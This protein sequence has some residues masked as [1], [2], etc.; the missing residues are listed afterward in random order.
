[1]VGIVSD[2]DVRGAA[3]DTTSVDAIM[4]PNPVTTTAATP[5]EDAAA[6]MRSRKIGA[7]P[8]LDGAELVGIVSESDLLMALIEL[9]R[10]TDPT[11][12]IDLD[13]EDD[14]EAAH[15]VRS[16]LERHGG[17][18]SWLTAIRTHGG[19]QRISLRV[20]LPHAH[21]PSQMLEEAGFSVVSCVTGRTAT[22]GH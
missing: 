4:T 20:R 8:V 10:A 13:C 12:V 21:T 7:L 14:P 17:T 22:A 5:V 18:V 9:C 19:R 1:V 11:A 16:L 15:R 6:L 2:R 3:D